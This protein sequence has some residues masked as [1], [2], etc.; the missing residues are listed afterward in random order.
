MIP[1]STKAIPDIDL[2]TGCERNFPDL[3]TYGECPQIRD[4]KDC[5]L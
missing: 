1:Q 5:T 2:A 3:K 4:F